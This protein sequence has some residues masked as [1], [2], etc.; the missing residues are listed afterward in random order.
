MKIVVQKRV[1]K[2]IQKEVVEYYCDAC[3]A[4]CGT[5][6]NKKST[7]HDAKNNKSMHYCKKK[8]EHGRLLKEE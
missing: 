6:E 7:W 5:K 4:R 2:V 8:C 3:G 1:V